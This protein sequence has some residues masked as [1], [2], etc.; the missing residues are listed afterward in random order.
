MKQV[1]PLNVVA[2]LVRARPAGAGL[3][4]GLLQ[5]VEGR[6]PG[7]PVAGRRGVVIDVPDQLAYRGCGDQAQ[8]TG[9]YQRCDVRFAE[10]GLDLLL[11]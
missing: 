2:D 8:G 1:A 3:G 10:H 7:L 4:Q 5:I 9:G 11:W 6:G